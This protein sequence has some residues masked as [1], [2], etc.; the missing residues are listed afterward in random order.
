MK[1]NLGPK[2]IPLSHRQHVYNQAQR[3]TRSK[4]DDERSQVYKLTTVKDEARVSDKVV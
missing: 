3:R 2:G 1:K 4:A